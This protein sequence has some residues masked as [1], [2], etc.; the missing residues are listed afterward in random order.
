M[1]GTFIMK[2]LRG[3]W[4]SEL[5]LQHCGTESINDQQN[6]IDISIED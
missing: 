1:T 4:E 5:T 3:A 6:D 2:G